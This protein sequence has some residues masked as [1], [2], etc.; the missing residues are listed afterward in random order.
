MGKKKKKKPK[1]C[2]KAGMCNWLYHN[3]VSPPRDFLKIEH[4]RSRINIQINHQQWPQE[5]N[6]RQNQRQSA[7][8]YHCT[9]EFQSDGVPK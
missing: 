7:S 5:K 6:H 1:K 9:V 8:Q 4:I 3:V 2:K